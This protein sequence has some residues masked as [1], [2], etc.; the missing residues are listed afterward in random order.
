VS[1]YHIDAFVQDEE[2]REWRLTGIY[3]EPKSEEKNKTWRLMRILYNQ[4]NK[5]W[6]CLGDFNEIL[7]GCEKEGG[8]PRPAAQMERFRNILEECKLDDLG[9]VGGMLLHGGT[10]I[11]ELRDTLKKDWTVLWLM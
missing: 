7:F 9:F 1:R 8:Q 6:L 3:G 4:F 10:I 2:G 5:L 11:T